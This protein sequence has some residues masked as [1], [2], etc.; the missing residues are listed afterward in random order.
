M[1]AWVTVT[2]RKSGVN[3]PPCP[4]AA[5]PEISRAIAGPG[6]TAA[7]GS[8]ACAV[9]PPSAIFSP[10]DAQFIGPGASQHSPSGTPGMLCSAKAQS[11]VS[12]AKR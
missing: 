2:I 10:T 9:L 12:A 11:G 5:S 1:R 8:A 3:S 7:S 6:D 4:R